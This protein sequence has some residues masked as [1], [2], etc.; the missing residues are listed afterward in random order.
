[1]K[2]SLKLAQKLLEAR[3]GVNSH[4]YPPERVDIVKSDFD[5]LRKLAEQVLKEEA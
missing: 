2:T 3:I 5:E 1:M 4:P